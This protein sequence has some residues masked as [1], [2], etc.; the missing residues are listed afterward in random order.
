MNYWE[1]LLLGIVQGLTEFLPISS[2][3]HLVIFQHLLQIK[4]SAITFEI[5]VHAGTLLSIFVVYYRD[6]LRMVFSFF[7]AMVRPGRKAAWQNDADLRLAV[8]VIIGTL[9][10]V[11]AGLLFKDFFELVFHNIRLV[12]I[13]LILTGL[14]LL[15]TRYIKNAIRPLTL[16]RCGIIGLAQAVA[17]LPGIS[18]SGATITS[19]LWLNLGGKEAMRFSFLLAVPAIVGALIL[20]LQDFM[21][22]DI[23]DVALPALTIGFL[24]AFGVGY[25]AIRT[26]LRIVQS[27][28][29]AWFGGYC[30]LVGLGVL[31]FLPV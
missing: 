12:G 27:G 2:S 18:R 31:L 16:T 4:S 29:F 22:G 3:G 8:G 11:V 28:R 9:P 24:T 23:G 21:P 7:G 1:A 19:G 15:S 5:A 10:A 13:T 26:L 6:L 14:I 17:I 25:I 30:L 20:H